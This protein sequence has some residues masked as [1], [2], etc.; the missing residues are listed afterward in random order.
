MGHLQL[1]VSKTGW[2]FFWPQCCRKGAVR[3]DHR[4]GDLPWVKNIFTAQR[5]HQVSCGQPQHPQGFLIDLPVQDHRF[6]SAGEKVEEFLAAEAQHG[7]QQ[8]QRCNEK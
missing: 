2:L 1:Q 3:L 8:F 7:A 4:V 6:G 5:F